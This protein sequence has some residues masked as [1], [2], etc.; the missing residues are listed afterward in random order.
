VLDIFKNAFAD[1]IA[2]ADLK[3]LLQ[4]IKGHLYKR[5]FAAAF[6]SEEYLEAYAVRWSPSRALAYLHIF[7]DVLPVI[8]RPGRRLRVLCL[9]AG[10]GAEVVALGGYLHARR[11]VKTGGD[12]GAVTDQITSD[13][14]CDIV[15][16]QSDT[17]DHPDPTTITTSLIDIAS[18][19]PVLTSL[20]TTMLL[21]P[22]TSPYAAAHIKAAAVPLL[23]SPNHLPTTFHQLDMLS[24]DPSWLTSSLPTAALTT[25]F[26]T[27]NEL[28]STSLARTK[29]LLLSLTDATPAGAHLL[30]VDSAGSYATVA[31]NG[32]AINYPMHWLLDATLGVVADAL[33]T[34][35][36]G[37]DADAAADG[38]GRDSS[39]RS[40]RRP[41]WEKIRHEP[42]C[43]FRIAEQLKYPRE[44]ENMRY[45]LLLYRRLEDRAGA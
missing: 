6:G 11:S 29:S 33:P 23:P 7:H 16:D 44:L 1:R 25:I 27:L 32:S 22:P 9:G 26:F 36:D 45:Q 38:A 14:T 19:S 5:D 43:W 3:S 24:P 21:P 28:F 13:A 35:A 37:A 12:V 40:G 2:S 18:W 20:Q 34:A 39:I 15:P 31:L 17:V 42:S 10:A 30:V 8:S 41:R 4:E